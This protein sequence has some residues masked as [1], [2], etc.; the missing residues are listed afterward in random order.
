MVHRAIGPRISELAPLHQGCRGGLGGSDRERYLG[1]ERDGGEGV[2]SQVENDTEGTRFAL[3]RH[4]HAPTSTATHTKATN[5]MSTGRRTASSTTAART[6]TALQ[7]STNLRCDV[8][9]RDMRP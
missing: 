6:A 4:C 9:L 2:R 1:V 5:T 8:I 7:T 3:G